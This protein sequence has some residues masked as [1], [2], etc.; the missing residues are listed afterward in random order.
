MTATTYTFQCPCCGEIVTDNYR[1]AYVI[2]APK[3]GQHPRTYEIC[4]ECLQDMYDLMEGRGEKRIEQMEHEDEHIPVSLWG[5][6]E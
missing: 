1:Q 4:A 5:H 2:I 6:H 3:S